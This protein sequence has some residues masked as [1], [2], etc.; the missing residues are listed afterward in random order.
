MF[1]S[2]VHFQHGAQHN[3]ASQPVRWLLPMLLSRAKDHCSDE[4]FKIFTWEIFHDHVWCTGGG[5]T[6]I[7]DLDNVRMF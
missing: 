3:Q 2:E 6:K 5:G 1:L 4:T 7:P